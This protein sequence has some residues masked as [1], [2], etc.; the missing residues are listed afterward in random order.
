MNPTKTITFTQEDLT[1]L[2]IIFDAAL[3][4]SGMSVLNQ[5]AIL[6]QKIIS[7]PADPQPKQEQT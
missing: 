7:T 1:A 4:G 3:K 5:V 2:Q 6:S